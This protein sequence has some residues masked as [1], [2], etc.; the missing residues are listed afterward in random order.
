MKM[1]KS[2][3]F[4]RCSNELKNELEKIAES[5][6]ISLTALVKSILQTYLLQQGNNVNEQI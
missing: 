6:D 5:K 3:I 4:F 2:I 1:N